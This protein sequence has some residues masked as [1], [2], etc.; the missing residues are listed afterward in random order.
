MTF[1]YQE[2]LHALFKELIQY[3]MEFINTFYIYINKYIIC[4][5]RVRLS[6][7][8]SQMSNIRAT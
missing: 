8:C 7:T 6:Y 5:F 3:S 4:V 2:D 1:G